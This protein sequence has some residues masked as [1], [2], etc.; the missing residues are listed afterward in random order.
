MTERGVG[1]VGSEEREVV[2]EKMGC[3]TDMDKHRNTD[4]ASTF[5]LYTAGQGHRCVG[6]IS[7]TCTTAARTMTF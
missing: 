7:L 2:M 5:L 1:E 4:I 3:Q 6:G